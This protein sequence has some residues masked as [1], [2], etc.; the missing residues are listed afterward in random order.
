MLWMLFIL[1]AFL[2][3][4]IPFGLL[5]G[6]M[7]GIDIRDHGSK[8]IGATNVGRVLGRRY[9]WFCF[10][11]DVA[12]G[13]IP[14]LLAGAAAG[15]LSMSWHDIPGIPQRD[16]WLWMTVAIAAVLGHMYSPFVAFKG[17]KGVATGFGAFAAMAPLTTLPAF[18]AIVVW[19]LTLR[20]TRF[21]SVSSMAAVVSMPVL[22][23][24]VLIVPEGLGLREAVAHGLPVLIVLIAIAALVIFKH[25]GNISRLRRG[26]EPKVGRMKRS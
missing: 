25:R 21:V 19:Y 23:V 11:L 2:A 12:K 17:G 5:I 14:V 26:E 1:I 16:M 13:A 22:Y 3:G 20:L 8:N 15:I 24:L 7:K 6:R 18:G 10:A 4:S 9:G